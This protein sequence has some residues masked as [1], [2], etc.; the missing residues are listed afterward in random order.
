MKKG[1]LIALLIIIGLVLAFVIG[2]G[3]IYLQFTA[4]PAIPSQT[5]LKIDI[6]GPF[7]DSSASS[8]L[9]FKDNPSVQD[10]WFQ[11]ERAAIDSRIRGVILRITETEAGFAKIKEIGASITR[12]RKSKKPVIAFFEGGGFREYYLATFAD[13]VVMLRNGLYFMYGPAAEVQFIKNTLAKLGID[14]DI[15]HTGDYKTAFNMYTEDKLTPAHRESV[16]TLLGDLYSVSLDQIAVN[17]KLDRGQLRDWMNISPLAPEDYLKNRMIDQVGYY[18]DLFQ[19]LKTKLPITDFRTYC[20]TST[21]NPF[22]GINKIAVIFASGEIYQGRSGGQSFSSTDIM[23]SETI[24]EHLRS[25]RNN[26]QIKAV[27]LR[28]DSPGGS[29]AAS[30]IIRREAELLAKKKPLVISMSNV[31]ASGGYWVAMAGQKIFAHPETI[32]GSIGV[33]SGKFVIKGFYDK[34]GLTKEIITTTKYAAMYSDYT[35]FSRDEREKITS[36]IRRL[37]DEF[38]RIVAANRGMKTEDVDQIAEGRVWSGK[39]AMQY[40]LIDGYGGLTEALTEAKKLARIPASESVGIRIYP[41][42]KSLLDLVFS[43]MGTKMTQKN[44]IAE[45]E[46]QLE[47]AKTF[48]PALAL[49][50]SLKIR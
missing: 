12:F 4:E 43:L 40:K 38:L 41:Q 15:I 13:K 42:K 28:I 46:A 29:A 25:A 18:D 16:E 21:P 14:A 44:P 27:V 35:A 31:A 2:V 7:P 36:E 20:K 3:L 37:Y 33:I 47:R 17:R 49:P 30:D 32:T 9:M 45:I 11:L 48:Y 26:S 50:Y 19:L 10:L 24:S 1:P 5:Y 34:I 22:P 39:R 6:A 23:G 8:S